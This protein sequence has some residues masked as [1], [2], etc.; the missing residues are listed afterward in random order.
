VAR[1]HRAARWIV[2]F[3]QGDP[4]HTNNNTTTQT[5]PYDR[6]TINRSQNQAQAN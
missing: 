4:P 5:Q 1:R 2:L 3:S 6:M